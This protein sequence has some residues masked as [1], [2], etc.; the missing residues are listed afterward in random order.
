MLALLLGGLTL[1]PWTA[2]EAQYFGQNRV[3]YRKF[4]FRVLS[5]EHFDIYYYPEEEAAVRIAARMAE[6][7]NTRLSRLLDFRFTDRQ[8]LILYAS[9]PDFEQTNTLGGEQPGEGTGGVTESFKRRVILPFAGPL[10]ETDHVL[11]HELVHAFQYAQTGQKSSGGYKEPIAGRLP[12]WFIEGMAEYLS[13]GPVDP[14]TAMWMRDAVQRNKLPTIRQLNSGRYFPYRWGQALWAYIGGRWGDPVVGKILKTAGRYGDGESAIERV[15]G[16]KIDALSKEWQ[17][18]L[19]AAYG[20]LVQQHAESQ[21]KPLVGGKGAGRMNLSP[22]VSPDG[23]ELVF[24]SEKS[25]FAIEMFVADAQSGQVTKR[26]SESAMDPHID[27]LQF[28]SSAGAWDHEG[29]RFVSAVVTRSVPAL[30]I[31]EVATGRVE[32]EVP[33][34]ELGEIYNPT[35]SPDGKRVAFA[36]LVGGLTDLFVYDLKASKLERLTEDAYADLQPAWSPDGKTIAFVTDRYSSNLDSLSFGNYRLALINPDTKSIAPLSAFGRVKNINPQW[37]PDSA[38]IYFVAD[39]DG[40]SNL[41]RVELSTGRLFQ[42]TDLV[43]GVSGITGIS[44]AI[45]SASNAQRV[46]FSV[47]ANDRYQIY[48]VDDPEKLAG[49]PV[50]AEQPATQYAALPPEQRSNDEIG[51]MR[52]DPDFGL[53]TEGKFSLK[54]YRPRLALDYVS[55]PYI[56]AGTD[57]FGSFVGGGTSLLFSDMLGDHMVS[58]TFQASGGINDIAVVGGY[59]NM[60]SR[61]NWG[62]FAGQVPYVYNYSGYGYD[63]SG[64]FVELDYYFYQINRQVYLMGAYPFSRAR[65]VELSGGFRRVSFQEEVDTSVIDSVGNVVSYDEQK[66]SPYPALNLAEGTAAYVYDTSIFG[67]T[68]P[69]LGKRYRLEMGGTGGSLNYLAAL[70]DFRAYVMPVR[71][72]TLAARVLHYGRYGGKSEDV[73][74]NPLFIGYAGLIRGY[75]PG[76]FT[77]AECGNC[78]IIDRISGSRMLIG[79]VELRFPLFGILGGSSYYGPFPIEGAVFYDAGVAW[80]RATRPALSG[81]DPKQRLPVGSI[82]GALRVNVLGYIV[83]EVDYVKP[84]DRPKKGAHWEF[85]FIPGF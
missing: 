67:A 64:D 39:R 23:R 54:P 26:I 31:V 69:V 7:W 70:V 37:S 61:F 83:V 9:H 59:Q 36:A 19:K 41:F 52:A 12:L 53:P 44:P 25:Q 15:L 6:R 82:G 76:S 4:D 22:A 42:V 16:T 46:L 45:S 79:N 28:I 32:R 51:S 29:K 38:S 14:N 10:A 17:D 3:Q 11:G 8:P 75:D 66:S 84:L 81:S 43:T 48:G 49:R 56:A 24:L 73:R 21:L 18:S 78:P 35:W 58:A 74:L 57:R 65:R 34:P 13:V 1:A 85:N 77:P 68:S 72:L 5:T 47:Y 40:I 33:L 20:P 63:M 55:Q 2:T 71:R 60:H 50:E 80:T 62:I 30:S 27:S